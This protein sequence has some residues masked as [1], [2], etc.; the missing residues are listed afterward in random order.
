MNGVYTDCEHPPTI[1]HGRTELIIDDYG[2]Q[3]TGSYSCESGYELVGDAT[4]ACNLDTDEWQGDLPVCKQTSAEGSP[5]SEIEQPD[6]ATVK[7]EVTHLEELEQTET[8]KRNKAEVAAEN[9]SPETIRA[10]EIP[11]EDPAVVSPVNTDDATPI[12]AET[13]AP[14]QQ[15][16]R[17]KGKNYPEDATID[18][19]FGSQLDA[20]CSSGDAVS[21]PDVN[22]AYVLKYER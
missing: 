8:E 10:P 9:I 7:A 11:P 20:S 6:S 19:A 18:E 3:V 4:L 12:E 17:R 1:L 21:A 5:V 22:N 2:T 16:R 14:T 15:K 13:E